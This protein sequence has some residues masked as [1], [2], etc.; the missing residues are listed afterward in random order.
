MVPP[1]VVVVTT[2]GGSYGPLKKKKRKEIPSYV[3]EGPRPGDTIRD[4][5]FREQDMTDEEE[6][7]FMLGWLD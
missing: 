2:T 3:A 4:M 7:I 6:L 5:F 1:P